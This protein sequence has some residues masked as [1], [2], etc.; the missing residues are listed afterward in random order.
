MDS[1]LELVAQRSAIR[2]PPDH[3]TRLLGET[4]PCLT[5]PTRQVRNS[6]RQSQGADRVGSRL[7]TA[8]LAWLGVLL[9]LGLLVL[10]SDTQD[11]PLAPTHILSQLKSDF[12]AIGLSL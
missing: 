6:D 7:S 11:S 4:P 9:F 5:N 12:P 2:L 10:H 3:E 8:W 1:L